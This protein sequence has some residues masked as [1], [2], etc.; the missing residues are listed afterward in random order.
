LAKRDKSSSSSS[1]SS[2]N[3]T[4]PRGPSLYGRN[5]GQHIRRA[6]L[7]GDRT[8]HSVYSWCPTTKILHACYLYKGHQKK[9]WRTLPNC[10]PS[11]TRVDRQSVEWRTLEHIWPSDASYA[12]PKA[13]T[14]RLTG[15]T[16][17][18]L[19]FHNLNR[20]MDRSL[21]DLGVAPYL[22]GFQWLLPS[23]NF[24]VGRRLSPLLVYPTTQGQFDFGLTPV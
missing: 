22:L 6:E 19:N 13:T 5:E 20:M 8:S 3:Y 17:I 12:V 15:P 24:A 10:R 7:R 2:H 16:G 14:K 23:A 18:T 11:S 1:S 4:T 21:S 9:R